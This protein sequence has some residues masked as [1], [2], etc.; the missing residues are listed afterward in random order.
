VTSGA[1]RTSF[2]QQTKS[3]NILLQILGPSLHNC[4]DKLSVYSIFL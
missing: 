3:P 4:N 1:S 2:L